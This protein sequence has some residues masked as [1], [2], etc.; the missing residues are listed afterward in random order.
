MRRRKIFYLKILL[1]DFKRIIANRGFF[2]G[3]N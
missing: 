3:Q 1:C 2:F